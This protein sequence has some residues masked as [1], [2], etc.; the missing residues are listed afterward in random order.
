MSNTTTAGFQEKFSAADMLAQASTET[1]LEDFGDEEFRE[2]L[3]RLVES[4]NN[5]VVL[6]PLGALAFKGE[7]H[8]I[9]VNRLRFAEDLRRHP[10]ILNENVSDPIVI[11]G[12]PRT[13][14]TKLQRFMAADP[15][16][17]RLEYWRL[18]NPAP[19]PNANAGEPDPRIQVAREA[20]SGMAKLM[21]KWMDS[22]PT[23]AEEVDEE[24]F[25]QL[26]TFKSLLTYDIRP[27]PGFAAWMATQS[28]RGTYRYMK[29]LL[30]YLQW[31]DG[32]KRGRPWI[33][34]SPIHVG[35]T[36]LLIEQ[37]PNATLVFTHRDLHQ[38]IPSHCRLMESARRLYSD[39]VDM[40]AI[41]RACI[42][43]WLEELQK[44]VQIRK[45][46]G[47]KLKIHDVQ[48]EQGRDDPLGVVREIY[49]CGGRELTP[50][51]EQAMLAWERAHPLH[52]AGKYSYRIEDYGITYEAIDAA[53]GDCLRQL[54]GQ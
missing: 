16:V 41:G 11:L 51:R 27:V 48:Y 5:D 47:S 10:E 2:A 49:R 43:R 1:G 26:Y 46:L 29:Q 39:D 38:V 37:F 36:D 3:T 13:G 7:V 33:L 8:R 44:H 35:T 14:T 22:H 32:G 23:S 45:R 6:S 30:Q 52:H 24:V 19:F 17:Q 53:F 40:H 21:P 34:K 15:D 4:T 25:L 28:L 12:L 31:Q 9:L 20:I 54:A 42:S 50:Q 18:L